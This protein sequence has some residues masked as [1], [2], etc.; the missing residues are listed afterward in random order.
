[1]AGP[2]PASANPFN[3]PAAFVPQPAGDEDASTSA[4]AA[5]VVAARGYAAALAAFLRDHGWLLEAHPVQL[6][7]QQPLQRLPAAWRAELAASDPHAWLAEPA[8][9]AQ[10]GSLCEWF[11]HAAALAMP[12]EPPAGGSEALVFGKDASLQPQRKG[13][14][15]EALHTSA[16]KAHELSRFASFLAALAARCGCRHI[17]DAGA[18][19]GRLGGALCARFGLSVTGLERDEAAVQ[20]AARRRAWLDADAARRGALAPDA[21]GCVTLHADVDAVPLPPGGRTVLT[22]LHACG[23]LTVDVLRQF[24][25]APESF[26]AVAVAGCCYQH[27]TSFPASAAVTDACGSA[28]AAAV[29]LP[30]RAREAAAQSATAAFLGRQPAPRRAELRKR[31]LA[32]ALLELLR[33]ERSTSSTS[34]GLDGAD[35]SAE[36]SGKHPFD[37]KVPFSSYAATALGCAWSDD[38]DAAALDAR[39][40]AVVAKEDGNLAALTALRCAAGGV[41]EALLVLDRALLLAEA[42]GDDVALGVTPLF[43][44][45]LSP[46][47]L[48][49]WARRLR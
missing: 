17:V 11:A 9:G 29:L 5:H 3:L 39:F 34:G 20:R 1:M 42:A 28:E 48:V 46:R 7:T 30:R 27:A 23:E 10:P 22:G 45:A 24:A 25:A 6:L 19:A 13:A 14:G 32:R 18:G 44:P 47:N 15:L 12:R 36:L 38:A 16:K 35:D 37:P 49:V 33:T 2:A 40:A 8:A 4:F 31:A 21:P 43:D 41:A 26:A